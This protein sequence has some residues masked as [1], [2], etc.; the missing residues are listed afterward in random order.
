MKIL[1]YIL[2][3]APMR[4][5]GLEQYTTSLV[6]AEVEK[7]FQVYC[8]YP[9]GFDFSSHNMKIKAEKNS[10]SLSDKISNFSLINA[11]PLVLQGAIYDPKPFMKKQDRNVFIR[12]LNTVKPDV[13]HVHTLMGLPIEFLSV[14][15]K[16]KIKIVYS[17]HD[18]F[19]ISPTPNFFDPILNKSFDQD[20]TVDSWIEARKFSKPVWKLRVFQLRSYTKIKNLKNAIPSTDYKKPRA[21]VVSQKTASMFEDFSRLKKYYAKMFH[22][23][24]IW[25]FNSELTRKVFKRHLSFPLHGEVIPITNSGVEKI[26]TSDTNKK[27]S[28]KKINIGYIGPFQQYKGFFTLINSFIKS[29]NNKIQLI[30]YGDNTAIKLPANVINKGRFDKAEISKVFSNIDL[31][32]VPS[33]WKETF[34]FTVLESIES[35]TPVIISSNVGARDLLPEDY[36]GVFGTENELICLLKKVDLQ[37]IGRLKKQIL[38]PKIGILDVTR[39]Y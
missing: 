31:L 22:L 8:L 5:G 19:G 3:Y 36:E 35:R 4:S 27:H 17:T 9:L 32:I 15:H 6:N 12:F 18:Y 11:F 28:K 21:E 38:V 2:G 13:I 7:G 24:D 34:A 39:L 33:V 1:H 30:L 26:C 29:D 10:D 16:K 37:L 23:I 20:D 14:A 25:H